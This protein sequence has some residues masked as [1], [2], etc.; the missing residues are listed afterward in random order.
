MNIKS[1]LLAACSLLPATY[2]HAEDWCMWGRTPDRMM[3]SPE[4]NPPTDWDV[5]TQKN[6]KW[7]AALG[8]QSY[9]NPVVCNGLV[10]IGTNN[11]GKRDPKFA[12][13]DG[14]P[15]DGGVLMIFRE[16]DGKFLWQQFNPK[17]KAGRVNDWPF[18][19][20]CATVYA[21][22]DFA[23]YCTN[24]CEVW[25]IDVSPL[26]NGQPEP[27]V[28][29]K[30][31][32]MAQYGVF[33]HNM[34]AS[35]I[36]AF[37][38]L[39]YVI[40]GN[41]VDESHKNIPNPKA[42]AI[43]CF[44]KK[45]GKMVWSD[46]TPGENIL[47]GQWASPALA[48]VKGR[49]LVIAPLGDGWIY[50]Y[51]AATGYIVWKFDSNNKDT[52]YPTTRNELIATPVIY[53]NKCYIANGQ[54]PE[55]GEGPGHL[56]CLDITKEGDIS[57]ELDDRPKPKPG[58]ELVAPT[59]PA[60][61]KPNPNSGVV[62]DFERLASKDG[63]KVPAKDQM[64]RSISSVAISD[65]LVFAPDFSG[66][67][68]CLD[69]NTGKMY[70]TYDMEAATWGS[71]LICDGKVYECNEDGDVKIFEIS[72]ELKE[73]ASHNMGSAVYGSPIIANGVLYVA[74]REK[75]FAIEQKK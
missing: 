44:N 38:D 29:W 63:K 15:T 42:P 9:A 47:H 64:H 14:T 33:P 32:M 43:I 23:Y 74:N 13:P 60:K 20:I 22:G 6:I 57:K 27:K 5:D 10:F 18:Q 56:W 49:E 30:V 12:N 25:C 54:D 24:R 72:K 2:S 51:D 11:E 50:A 35:S 40:T 67:F 19:G 26:R 45:D 8:S 55:H 69:A 53:D 59:G 41:G 62:W 71:P 4:K 17:L 16:K 36:C 39:I 31:D 70:W 48:K 73:I 3:V 66:F 1:L 34:T 37:G 65:G 52:V 46:N 28:A 7:H 61:T 21:E 75:L 58:D 68:H